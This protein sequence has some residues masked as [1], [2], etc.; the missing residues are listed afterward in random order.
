MN[1][2]F[3][4]WLT[5]VTRNNCLV[6]QTI[7]CFEYLLQKKK[8]TT[9]NTETKHFVQEAFKTELNKLFGLDLNNA[10]FNEFNDNLT[11]AFNKRTPVKQGSIRGNSSN[12]MTKQLRKGIM[13]W[14][15]LQNKFLKYRTEESE[16]IYNKEIFVVVCCVKPK[17]LSFL[18]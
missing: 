10:E 17:E 4:F 18:N 1:V 14:S 12:F 16:V 13:T 9:F 8:P 3:V 5:L 2:R 11:S 7:L 6:I 15:R